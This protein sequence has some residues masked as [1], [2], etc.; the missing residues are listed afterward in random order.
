[1]F[2][3]S[4]VLT[5][6]AGTTAA[7]EQIA[8][9][10]DAGLGVSDPDS[11]ALASATVAITGNFQSGQD[12]LAF[13][14]DGLTMG[15]IAGSYASGTGILT[16]TSSGATATLAQWAAALHAVTFDDTSDTPST[17]NRTISFTVNDGISNSNV[18]TKTVS[19]TAVNDPPTLA[20]SSVGS[21]FTEAAGVGT[22]GATVAVFSGANAGTVEAGQ[23][24]IGL[25]FTVGG[26]VDGANENLVVDG[27]AITLGA[28]SSGTTATNGMSYGVTVSGGSATIALTKAAGVSVAN[29]DT[30]I[31]GI[32]YQNTNTD[33]P[34]AGDR[35]FTLTQIQDSGGTANSGADT[36]TVSIA[37]AVHVAAVNDPPVLTATAGT[38]ASFEQTPIAIDTGLT[39]T[40]PDNTT[41]ASATV[42]ITGNFHSAEDVL[43][44]TNDGLTMGN[45][46]GGY[47]PGIGI[48]ALTS[49]GGSATL[50]QWAAALHAVTY[51][52]TSDT[53]NTADRTISFVVNDGTSNSIAGTKTVSVAAVNDPPV[54]SNVATNAAFSQSQTVTLSPTLAATDPDNVNLAGATVQITGGAFTGDGDVLAAST[55]G[56]TITASYDSATEKL[57][58][59]GT[60]TLAHYQSV[61]D[62][63]TFASGGDPTN[64][65]R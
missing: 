30:L 25:T 54:L 34:T 63:V 14:N 4:P 36:A 59:S 50:A 32:T 48:L 58:L 23:T 17:A 7:L 62:G 29:I 60:D 64:G 8:I 28:N 47:N 10:I 15:N 11:T 55:T 2:S 46:V 42:A 52:D 1:V 24:I 12:V 33:N 45:I 9:A 37:S 53:P 18:V 35:T 13:V 19:V 5:A 22:Q 39:V 27:T 61:L 21:T 44:F 3:S 51:D 56:T 16:L 31:N 20:A 65:G 41:L 38:T 43:A 6:T 49:A 57:T 40:D 26:L